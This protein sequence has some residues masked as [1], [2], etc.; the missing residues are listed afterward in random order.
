MVFAFVLVLLP[1]LVCPRGLREGRRCP[2]FRIGEDAQVARSPA[3]LG[4]EFSKRGRVA[5]VVGDHH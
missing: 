1:G 4:V 3:R 5:E 2:G